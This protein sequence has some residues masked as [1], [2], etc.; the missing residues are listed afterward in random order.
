MFSIPVYMHQYVF[1]LSWQLPVWTFFLFLVKIAFLPAHNRASKS[2]IDQQSAQEQAIV[3]Q[4]TKTNKDYYLWNCFFVSFLF[5]SYSV[6]LL[7]MLC[8][9]RYNHAIRHWWKHFC[10]FFAF[11]MP[12]ASR[13]AFR[14]ITFKSNHR[15]IVFSPWPFPFWISMLFAIMQPLSYFGITNRVST[16]ERILRSKQQKQVR[17]AAK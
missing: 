13:M 12:A 1:A 4:K 6:F 10:L 3:K 7:D 2:G 16:F 15:H 9:W 11:R 5:G 8:N 14:R 17:Q